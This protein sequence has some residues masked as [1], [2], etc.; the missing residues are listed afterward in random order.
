MIVWLL[1]CDRLTVKAKGVVPVSPSAAATSLMLMLIAV[2]VIVT[3]ATLERA[4]PSEALK[5]IGLTGE[6]SVAWRSWYS[7]PIQ[8]PLRLSRS[9]RA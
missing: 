3:V 2:T 5:A 9:T 4:K 7:G 8:L 6:I 1:G